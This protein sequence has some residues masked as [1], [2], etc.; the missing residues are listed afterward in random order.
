MAKPLRIF[1]IETYKAGINRF[2]KVDC[3]GALYFTSSSSVKGIKFRNRDNNVEQ[4]QGLTLSLIEHFQITEKV[5][6]TKQGFGCTTLTIPPEVLANR[7]YDCISEVLMHERNCS[8]GIHASLRWTYFLSFF[9]N[10]CFDED[11]CSIKDDEHKVS[12]LESSSEPGVM[13]AST[14]VE[15]ISSDVVPVEEEVAT[16]LSGGSLPVEEEVLYRCMFVEPCQ[17]N[18]VV[19]AFKINVLKSFLENIWN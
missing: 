18:D 7:V 5:M 19:S 1:K 17:V 6:I 3:G 4:L 14:K 12:R 11:L 9:K 13:L 10:L 2:L 8:D 15:R 16:S